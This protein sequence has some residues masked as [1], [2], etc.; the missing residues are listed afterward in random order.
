MKKKKLANP[1]QFAAQ[2]TFRHQM[3]PTK[4]GKLIKMEKRNKQRG[5]AED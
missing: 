1:V 2:L 4:K 3:T 5:Y